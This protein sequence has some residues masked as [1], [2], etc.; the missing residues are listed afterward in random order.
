ML[1]H[2][3]GIAEIKTSEGWARTYLVRPAVKPFDITSVLVLQPKRVVAGVQ[4]VWGVEDSAH[5]SAAAAAGDSAAR[6]GL[7]IIPRDTIPDM[8]ADTSDSGDA[9]ETGDAGGGGG[10]G[11]TQR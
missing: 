9:G 10:G 6:R 1:S 8:P 4:S 5:R 2:T 11:R 3:R 7:I